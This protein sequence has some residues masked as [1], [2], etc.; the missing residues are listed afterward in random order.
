MQRGLVFTIEPSAYGSLRGVVASVAG[1]GVHSRGSTAVAMG[2]GAGAGAGSRGATGSATG[3]AL[4][5][6]KSNERG[7]GV[8]GAS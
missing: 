5:R 4:G 3:G 6:S 2:A 7:S 8:R 1:V